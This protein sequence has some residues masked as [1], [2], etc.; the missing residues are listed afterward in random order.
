[1]NERLETTLS[2]LAALTKPMCEPQPCN[3]FVMFTAIWP[4][5]WPC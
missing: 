4:Q 3:A 1:M 2:D 5:E